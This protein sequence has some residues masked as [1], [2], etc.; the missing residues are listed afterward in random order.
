M[1]EA[2]RHAAPTQGAADDAADLA[3]QHARFLAFLRRR[4]GREA[5]AEDVLQSAYVKALQSGAALRERSSIVAW[6]FQVLRR[7]AAD[8]RRRARTG[9]RALAARAARTAEAEAARE[10][11]LRS[12]ACACVEALLPRLPAAQADLLRRVDLGG[13]SPR[14]AAAALGITA[15]SAAVRLHRGRQ[16]LRRMLEAVCGTCT[17]H[18][19]LDCRCRAP[20]GEGHGPM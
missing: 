7:A 8:H 19:C 5:D 10:R 11:S 15:G 3:R 2:R 4:L 14:E 17:R 13:A 9:A 6:F 18:R 20:G 16:A 1:S 12:A